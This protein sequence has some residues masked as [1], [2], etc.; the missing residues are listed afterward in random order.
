MPG[1]NKKSVTLLE[2]KIKS[3]KKE[4]KILIERQEL[5]NKRRDNLINNSKEIWDLFSSAAEE[6]KI[7]RKR[8][9]NYQYFIFSINGLNSEKFKQI[10]NDKNIIT[11]D[12]MKN[13]DTMTQQIN[14]GCQKLSLHKDMYI[15]FIIKMYKNYTDSD[16]KFVEKINQ[17][18]MKYRI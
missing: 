8:L 7:L 11:D 15:K 17:H 6:N 18:I 5:E 14:D 12:Y 9:N 13:F 16:R 4:K 1:K 10:L 2:K 3:L